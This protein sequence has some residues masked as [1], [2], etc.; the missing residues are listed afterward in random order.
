MQIKSDI[1]T[2]RDVSLSAEWEVQL[3]AGTKHLKVKGGGD[4][5][6]LR[7]LIYFASPSHN[8]RNEAKNPKI[9]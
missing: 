3:E 9:S 4:L 1:S 7:R 5:L 8:N 2:D 6:R